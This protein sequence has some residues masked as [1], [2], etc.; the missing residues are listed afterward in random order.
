MSSPRV[1][2]HPIYNFGAGP[3][4]LPRAVMTR[5][6]E[7]LLNWRGSGV[8]V[9]EVSH[10][11]REFLEV[12]QQSAR[13]L[14]ALLKVPDH[15]RILFAQ[16]GAS[17]LM[18]MVPLNLCRRDETADYV[19]TGSW[20][21]RAATEAGRHTGVNIAASAEDCNFTAVPE[22]ASWQLSEPAAYLYFCDNETIA[23]VEFQAVPEL[24]GRDEKT[25]LVSDMTSNFLSR[26]VP[27][28]RYGVIF[29]GAQKNIGPAGLTVVIIREDLLEPARADVPFLYDFKM[30]AEHE[31]MFNTPPTFNWYMAGLTFAWVREQGG[32]EQMHRNALARSG[33]LYAFIDAADFYNNPVAPRY[34][35][36]MN[37][38][39]T[40]A[41]T[42]LDAKFLAEAADH[43]MIALKGHRSV[44]GMRASMYNGLPQEAVATLIEFMAEFARLYG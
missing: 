44:G 43:G 22:L 26:P 2:T 39:F 10:R 25:P 28:E 12:A 14:A 42:D 16:G 40:L 21:R 7:E 24:A 33:R 15:Y 32:V 36:R 23:G 6:Q 38:P 41:D 1:A 8:S 11:S 5:A 17:H 30:L 27:V 29:A 3:A 19:L 9:M 35:S 31:S 34:R 18:S 20:S 4:T 37:V 13:D